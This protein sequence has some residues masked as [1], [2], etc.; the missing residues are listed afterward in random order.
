MKTIFI[1]TTRTYPPT[2]NTQ[3]QSVIENYITPEEW[4]DNFR[5]GYRTDSSQYP[6][7]KGV[8]GN[9]EFYVA[10][11]M[12]ENHKDDK[13]NYIRNLINKVHE[14]ISTND[15]E[16]EFQSFLIAHDWD[17]CSHQVFAYGSNEESQYDSEIPYF[18][19]HLIGYLSYKHENGKNLCVERGDNSTSTSK[20]DIYGSF[21]QFLNTR[22]SVENVKNLKNILKELQLPVDFNIEENETDLDDIQ[23]ELNVTCSSVSYEIAEFKSTEGITNEDERKKI[24]TENYKLYRDR[25]NNIHSSK[26]ILAK[27]PWPL[28]RLNERN[29]N[30]FDSSI[31]FYAYHNDEELQWIKEQIHTNRER[32]KLKKARE[33]K[34]FYSR[35][36][37]EDY[38]H[39]DYSSHAKYVIPYLFHSE[40]KLFEDLK[41]VEHI[42]ILSKIK[43]YKWRFLLVDDH[44]TDKMAVV[45]GEATLTKLD[46]V[47]TELEK[48]FQNIEQDNKPVIIATEEDDEKTKNSATIYIECASSIDNAKNNKLKE[49]KYEVIL[50]DYLLGEKDGGR[51]Y[52]YELLDWIYKQEKV[53]KGD[54]SAKLDYKKGPD[55]RFFFMFISAFTT[56]VSE[57]LLTE[58]WLRSED[59]WYI[60][61]G[62]CPIN[63][64]YLFQYRLLRIMDKRM[65]DMGLAKWNVKEQETKDD[66][67]KNKQDQPSNETDIYTEII[68]EIYS[69]DGIRKRANEKFQD[70]LDLLYHYKNLLLDTDMP[71]DNV[72]DS[73]ES[74]LATD[75]VMH[76]MDYEGVLEH[77]TQ[78]VYL[79]AFGTV[80]QWPEMWEEYQYIKSYLGRFQCVEDFI[81]N[82]KNNS[83][84]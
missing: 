30:F 33:Y 18:D 16:T 3:F 69:G 46:I 35:M 52:G 78:L 73:A 28:N 24:N 62:A 75:F 11:C 50:L 13:F 44:C 63:T 66:S 20:N 83:I 22:I 37:E 36:W 53:A 47:K 57:R 54:K 41:K 56:A 49:K 19:T 80:R 29:K 81:V 6:V 51:E 70:V 84:K 58:G 2:N 39:T 14:Y 71:S 67:A 45:D 10:P 27:L 77:L 43:Q 76:H 23:N 42:S 82:L 31:W 72:F 74:V 4:E 15:P 55:N 26:Q 1:I 61:E 34:E 12:S 5:K 25:T 32:Y 38:F 9:V 68:N 79:T 40:R 17:Y 65:K 64:P 48:L 7:K 59:Y 8:V 21:I 60:G